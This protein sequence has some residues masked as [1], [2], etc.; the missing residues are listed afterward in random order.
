MLL[1]EDKEGMPFSLS[2]DG[3][4]SI[5]KYKASHFQ[6]NTLNISSS[7]YKKFSL[8]SKI[9]TIPGA[10]SGYYYNTSK[11]STSSHSYDHWGSR[12]QVTA[13]MNKFQVTP[14]WNKI[15][16]ENYFA[17]GLGYIFPL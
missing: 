1:K 9:L 8:S 6:T 7:I 13:L 10:S 17:I 2:L 14:S 12:V 16:G 5:G 11:G 3:W 15:A 4:Y